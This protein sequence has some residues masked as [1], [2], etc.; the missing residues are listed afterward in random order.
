MLANRY[1]Q[2]SAQG[3]ASHAEGR[4]AARAVTAY[5]AVSLVDHRAAV[6]DVLGVSL[7]A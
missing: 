5:A 1:Q 4:H 3:S 6:S 2:A 7:Y